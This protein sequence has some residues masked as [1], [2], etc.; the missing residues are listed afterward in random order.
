MIKFYNRKTKSYEIEKISGEKL[1]N[2]LYNSKNINFLDIVTKKKFFSYIYGQYCDSKL[3][4]LKIKSF[5]NN[6]NIDMNESL[7][8]IGEFNSFN[9]FFTRKLKSNSRTTYGNKNILISP[10]DSKV[11]AF[12]NIDINKIIQVKGSNYSFKELLNSDKLCEQY[13]NG[14]CIIFR[15]CPT[16]YHRFHFIDSGICTETNKINGYYYSVNPIALE[17]IPS[18]FCKNKREWSILKS[19]NFGDILYMEVGATCVGTIVQT[20]TAN[21]EVSK[22]QEKGYF[23]F[24]GSTVILFFEKNKVS[25][26]KDILM[27]SNLGYETK[28]LI[29]DKIGKKFCSK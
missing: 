20:Y 24:G 26:D 27:Q 7:K 15:L 25:I 28:V 1:L 10:A 17:K 16:D 12:E 13:K 6:F 29:G 23:K 18:L 2:W 3:S 14:S 22:G 9:D 4:T 8:S 5:V 21:K 11:L 19:N